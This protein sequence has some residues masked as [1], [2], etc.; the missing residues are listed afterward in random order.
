MYSDK[1]HTFDF[2]LTCYGEIRN[3][4]QIQIVIGSTIFTVESLEI[5][6]ENLFII[7]KVLRKDFPITSIPV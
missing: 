3:L 5:G 2:Y 4:Q 7:A 1:N 6:L